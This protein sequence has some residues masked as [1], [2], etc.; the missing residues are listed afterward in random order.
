MGSIMRG[1]SLTLDIPDADRA[2]IV[3]FDPRGNID[4]SRKSTSPIDGNFL[5]LNVP[6]GQRNIISYDEKG[7]IRN[8]FTIRSGGSIISSVTSY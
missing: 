5:I 7:N 2:K 1:G 4:L 8:Y 6:V 3:Y